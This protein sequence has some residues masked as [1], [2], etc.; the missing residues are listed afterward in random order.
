MQHTRPEAE[1]A[2]FKPSLAARLSALE[3]AAGDEAPKLVGALASL[4]SWG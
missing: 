3:A 1:I 2:Q 4:L